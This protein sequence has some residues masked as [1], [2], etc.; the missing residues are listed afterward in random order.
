MSVVSSATEANFV[1]NLTNISSG[2]VQE[3]SDTRVV[4]SPPTGHST[5]PSHHN[6][7]QTVK[8]SGI[9]VN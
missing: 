6:V 8:I 3:M 2:P 1:F 7:T 9:L 5:V 4:T